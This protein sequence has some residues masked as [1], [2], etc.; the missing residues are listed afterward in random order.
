MYT[1]S[2]SL[3][4]RDQPRDQVIRGE[5]PC[6]YLNKHG[7]R[8]YKDA[9]DNRYVPDIDKYTHNKAQSG[10]MGT[11]N[12]TIMELKLRNCNNKLINGKYKY[13]HNKNLF[14]F[15]WDYFQTEEAPIPIFQPYLS[16]ILHSLKVFL[17]SW[18]SPA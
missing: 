2:N 5:L 4:T 8:F 9:E 11:F 16:C 15:Y 18:Y 1:L 17:L 14:P 12:R 10:E 7:L 6:H 3:L 13:I